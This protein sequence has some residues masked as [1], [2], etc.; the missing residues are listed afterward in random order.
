MRCLDFS[1][2]VFG[3]RG[4]AV[5]AAVGQLGQSVVPNSAHRS[6]TFRKMNLADTTALVL[7]LRALG[8]GAV[9]PL[10]LW[11]SEVGSNHVV[12]GRP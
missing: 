2:G 12:V 7:S 10:S 5:T 8:V 6:Q 4:P 11:E 9:Y 3:S 1:V